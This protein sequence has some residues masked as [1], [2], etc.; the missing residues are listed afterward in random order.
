MASQADE[1]KI[2]GASSF[3]NGMSVQ[4]GGEQI[5]GACS[6]PRQNVP[7]PADRETL[8]EGGGLLASPEALQNH[9]ERSPQVA[10]PSPTRSAHSGSVGGGDEGG[11]ATE[12][13]RA[14]SSAWNGVASTGPFYP[15]QSGGPDAN[16]QDLYLPTSSLD[17]T[18]QPQAT[19]PQT[20]H[21]PITPLE[22]RLLELL[23]EHSQGGDQVTSG[24]IDTQGYIPVVPQPPPS[25]ATG[26]IHPPSVHPPSRPQFHA[27]NYYSDHNHAESDPRGM[28]D[29]EVR[30]YWTE[31]ERKWDEDMEEGQ[32]ASED[33]WCDGSTVLWVLARLYGD[34]DGK[35]KR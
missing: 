28:D 20:I 30:E 11:W 26:N 31:F 23:N 18:S 27:S 35:G 24:P 34:G 10:L 19:Q 22:Q 21:Q 8:K 9:G 7:L 4:H 25:A 3:R 2:H 29:E 5:G 6:E 13:T 17:M 15:S 16:G 12:D 14:T 1:K 33:L 32:F